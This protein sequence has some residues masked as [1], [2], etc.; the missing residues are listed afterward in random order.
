MSIV[1]HIRYTS[2][3]NGVN[4]IHSSQRISAIFYL[5]AFCDALFLVSIKTNIYSVIIFYYLII[6]MS[7]FGQRHLYN[8]VRVN[9]SKKSNFVNSYFNKAL[10][11]LIFKS[12]WKSSL[13]IVLSASLIQIAIL[14]SSN[15]LQAEEAVIFLISI[16]L[17]RGISSFSQALF[18][19]KY[20]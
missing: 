19:Q 12:V 14:S 3:L 4:L 6:S 2:I 10:N 9:F 13:G 11:K 17:I 1:F 16:Q 18:I 8:K 7:I 5:L 15:I 20:Q